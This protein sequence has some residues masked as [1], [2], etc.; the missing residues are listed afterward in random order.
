MSSGYSKTPLVR[1]LGI[2]P[3]HAVAVIDG[4][5]DFVTWLGELPEGAELRP[6]L[7]AAPDVAVV[8]ATER[9]RLET[10]LLEA[11]DAIFP[12]G[13]VWAAWPKRA[14]RVPTDITEDTVREIALPR[15]LVDNKVCAISEVWS[16]LRVVWRREHRGGGPPS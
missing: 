7:G 3:G 14:S 16:G 9:A 10:A 6:A 2:K 5:A 13:A 11:A 4:P 8:F 15:G 1:K 12:A